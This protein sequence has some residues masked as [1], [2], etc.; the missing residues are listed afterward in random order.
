MSSRWWVVVPCVGA[1]LTA[2]GDGA[3]DDVRLSAA[4]ERG[5]DLA[6]T[7]GCANCHSVTGGVVLGPTWKGVWA[8]SVV[9]ADGDTVTFDADYVE[10][11]VRNPSLQRRSGNWPQMPEYPLDALSDDD[12]ASIV[13]Y[14]RDLGE[15]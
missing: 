15:S 3:S 1:L 9:L 8:T 6:S 12:L 10:T 14:I 2:C 7:E 11:S 4:G 13:A 5:R